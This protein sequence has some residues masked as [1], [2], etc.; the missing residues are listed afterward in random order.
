MFDLNVMYIFIG[1]KVNH[2]SSSKEYRIGKLSQVKANNLHK[3]HCSLLPSP[4]PQICKLSKPP[5]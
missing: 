2:T 1:A 5:F 4:L 3:A